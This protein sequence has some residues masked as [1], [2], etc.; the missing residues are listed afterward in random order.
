MTRQFSFSLTWTGILVYKGPF[1]PSHAAHPGAFADVIAHAATEK[2]HADAE[3]SPP[4][5]LNASLSLISPEAFPS[6]LEAP[7]LA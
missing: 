3:H 1:V 2:E 5:R 6:L 4:P 7:T